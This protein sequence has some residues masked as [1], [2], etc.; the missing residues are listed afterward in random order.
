MAKPDRDW[1]ESRN[2]L[3]LEEIALLAKERIR[4]LES[5]QEEMIAYIAEIVIGKTH[6]HGQTVNIFGM[7]ADEEGIKND[8]GFGNDKDCVLLFLEERDDDFGFEHTLREL[9]VKKD[10]WRK[11]I[12]DAML[13]L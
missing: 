5:T 10:V 6:K 11:A 8:V 7:G 1:V 9:L 3:E 12:K 4:I 13:S 2:V